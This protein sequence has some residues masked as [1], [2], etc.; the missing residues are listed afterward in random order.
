MLGQAGIASRNRGS[1]RDETS[2]IA[3]AQG[4]A[5][6]KRNLIEKAANFGASP[7]FCS[8]GRNYQ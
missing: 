6:F 8:S 4:F 5:V 1:E 2:S 7:G 3:R